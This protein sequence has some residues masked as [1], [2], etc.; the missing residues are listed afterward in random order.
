MKWL[1]IV[2]VLYSCKHI[3]P[4]KQDLGDSDGDLIRNNEEVTVENKFIA[5]YSPLGGM[6]GIM[7]FKLDGKKVEL[8]FTNGKDLK[9]ES[10]QLLL[11][12]K[13]L[14][15]NEPYFAEH[16]YLRPASFEGELTNA[17]QVNVRLIFDLSSEKPEKLTLVSDKGEME[18]G[19]W[20]QIM[21]FTLS[22]SDFIQVLKGNFR[23]NLVKSSKKAE[24]EDTI[25]EKTYRVFY[26]DGLESKVFYVSKEFSFERFMELHKI[27]DVIDITK[28][29][30]HSLE[31]SSHENWWVKSVNNSDKVLVKAS[32]K[33]LKESYL[34]Y[35][36]K[37]EGLIERLNGKSS[38]V[39]SLPSKNEAMVWLKLRVERS[40]K[41]FIEFAKSKRVHRGRRDGEGSDITCTDHYR[42]VDSYESVAVTEEDLLSN[43][44]L[45]VNGVPSRLNTIENLELTQM[46]DE[47]GPYW[48]VVFQANGEQLS[49]SLDSLPDST[50]VETGIYAANCRGRNVTLENHE[51]KFSVKYESYIEKL[52]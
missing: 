9:L 31:E 7:S 14:S 33:S 52:E 11:Q 12:N 45:E 48:E 38:S 30:V 20:A 51:N 34:S 24:K 19:K 46:S 10:F 47:L 5:D 25:I 44:S 18:V 13:K 49:L 50:Y 2:L 15:R 28:F 43:I 4:P 35:F 36:K 27:L 42:V 3:N 29:P 39:V 26:H 23:F 22:S 8:P 21:E 37:T 32:P 40:F 16:T 6:K 17:N 41:K 1:L